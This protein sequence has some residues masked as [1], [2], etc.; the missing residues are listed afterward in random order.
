VNAREKL[1]AWRLEKSLSQE[2]AA[3]LA[4]FTQAAWS[5]YEADRVPMTEHALQIQAVTAGSRHHVRVEEWMPL[6]VEQREVR[7]RKRRRGPH[8]SHG[9][10]R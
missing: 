1:K 5:G 8:P 6:I 2:A 9:D 3:K 10:G 7:A 4:G